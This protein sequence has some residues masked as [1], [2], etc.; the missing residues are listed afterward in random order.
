[1]ATR[2]EG[3][4]EVFSF[5]TGLDELARAVNMRPDDVAYALVESGLALW[6][7][8]ERDDSG[9]KAN[10]INGGV[11]LEESDEVDVKPRDD[12]KDG[13]HSTSRGGA[14]TDA[15]AKAGGDSTNA[16]PAP[17][18]LELELVITPELVEQVAREKGVKPMPMLDIAYVC[19][20]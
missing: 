12:A 10:G 1:M 6:R 14:E 15:A 18:D 3:G 9:R 11:K 2:V 16:T 5:A 8:G 4:E 17:N 13:S 7:R 20:L 19:D